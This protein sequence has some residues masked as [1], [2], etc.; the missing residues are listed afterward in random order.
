[1]KNKILGL[2]AVPAV[3]GSAVAFAEDSQSP[4]IPDAFTSFD[5]TSLITS[6]ATTVAPVLLA[7]LGL[8]AG[9]YIVRWCW[10]MLKGTAK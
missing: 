7:V 2:L 9:V 1:M 8:A 5:W 3:L 10:K 6:M 4:S